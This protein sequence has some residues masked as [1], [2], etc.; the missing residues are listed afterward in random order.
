ME[1][2]PEEGEGAGCAEEE[3]EEGGWRCMR[4]RVLQ[5][6][7]VSALDRA[8]A[9]SMRALRAAGL[10]DCEATVPGPPR[11]SPCQV[12]EDEDEEDPRA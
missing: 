7:A 1:L 11:G 10:R 8:V 6:P 12:P 2:V 5:V 9:T 4:H 3:D